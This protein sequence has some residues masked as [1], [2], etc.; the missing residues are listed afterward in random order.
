MSNSA[1]PINLLKQMRITHWVKN[2]LIFAP[3]FFSVGFFNLVDFTST[4]MLFMTFSFLASAV[5]IFNDLVDFKHDAQHPI[6]KK[7]P[8]ASGAI[9]SRQAISAM[10]ALLFIAVLLMLDFN[11]LTNII[12]ILYIVLN[13]LYSL[14]LKR[15]PL[16]DIFTVASFYILRILVGGALLSIFVSNWI[17]IVTFF[18]ALFLVVGKRR[19]ELVSQDTTNNRTTNTRLVLTQYSKQALDYSLYLI[20]AGVIASY[21]LYTIETDLPYLVYSSFFVTFGMLRYLYIIHK[22]NLG[23]APEKLVW[24]DRWVLATVLS[25]VLYMLI[26]F[27]R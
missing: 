8:I 1:F 6:K 14:L 17:V 4:A 22:Y 15:I 19:T 7:R 11:A 2:L 3:L 18:L 21:T 5:Y 23:E 27:Y 16:V 9:N 26:V 10:V 24:Q 20:I 13:I 12:L 25:W